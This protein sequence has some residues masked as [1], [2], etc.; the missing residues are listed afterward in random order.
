[1]AGADSVVLLHDGPRVWLSEGDDGL[2]RAFRQP[3]P[4]DYSLQ[5]PDYDWEEVFVFLPEEILVPVR[6]CWSI[7]WLPAAT[8]GRSARVFS[9]NA[10]LPARLPGPSG[11]LG[12]VAEVRLGRVSEY[13]RD[14]RLGDAET[15][16]AL[17]AVAHDRASNG[18]RNSGS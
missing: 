6:A 16:I 4:S 8:A 12:P 2:L 18:S 14:G 1:M 13:A 9:F 5:D 10:E 15:L 3:L 11:A 7:A 17:L